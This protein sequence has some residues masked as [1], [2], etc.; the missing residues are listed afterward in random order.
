[1]ASHPVAV[2][3]AM[4]AEAVIMAVVF[5]VVVGQVRVEVAEQREVFVMVQVLL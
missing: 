2:V 3:V 5:R 4:V 1:M